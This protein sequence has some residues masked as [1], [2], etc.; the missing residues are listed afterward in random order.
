MAERQAVNLVRV[1]SN[2]AK[3]VV[4]FITAET[5]NKYQ[6]KKAGSNNG[7]SLGS[8][9]RNPVRL[10]GLQRMLMFD[11]GTMAFDI[12]ST[13]ANITVYHKGS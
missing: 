10:G 1:G 12:G 2:P 13:V 9:P 11:S 8:C 3:G 6:K 4:Y 7:N 5:Q